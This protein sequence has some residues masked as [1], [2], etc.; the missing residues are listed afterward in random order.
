MQHG[1]HWAY[2]ECA[3]MQSW[4]LL[5]D[6]KQTDMA[7][8]LSCH[9]SA[10]CKRNMQQ[11]CHSSQSCQSLAPAH[12]LGCMGIDSIRVNQVAINVRQIG[13]EW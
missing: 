3:L 5:E 4:V 11:H 6:Q 10:S 8:I 9:A 12:A 7:F 1:T 13:V 2:F